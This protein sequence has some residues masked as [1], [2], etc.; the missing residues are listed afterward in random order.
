MAKKAAKPKASKPEKTADQP[1]KA[2]A[3]AKARSSSGD[4][5]AMSEQK[6]Q[7]KA[8]KPAAQSKGKS[9]PDKYADPAL[10]DRLKDEIMKGDK[11]GKPGQWSARKAQLLA[12]EYKKAGGQYKT[13]E[14]HKDEAQ[15]HLDQWTDEDWKTSDGKPAERE[16]GT[17]RYLPAE[18]WDK[19]TPAQK[20][21]TNA[22]KQEGS[23][24]GEQFVANTDEAKS[25][26]KR[27]SGK[28]GSVAKPKAKA[29]TKAKAP[30]RKSASKA[31]TQDDTKTKAKPKP[32]P[33]AAGKAVSKAKTKKA[34]D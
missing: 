6:P 22:K 29:N 12:T 15:E 8:A 9:S 11:G 23:R 5:K 20:R 27:A 31:T 21:A 4:S 17:T 10:R 3:G 16:G 7:S 30:A 24:E 33:K 1:K 25:A 2:A 19:L 13:D 18:A 14:S 28:E 34:S 26:R 32:K